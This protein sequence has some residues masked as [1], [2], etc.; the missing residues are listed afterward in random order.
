[1]RRG[2]T[3]TTL[4]APLLDWLAPPI[5][6][7]CKELYTP[8][9]EVYCEACQ[10]DPS[11]QMP[12]GTTS[13]QSC[14]EQT[15][16]GCCPLCQLAAMPL[17]TV[18]SAWNYEGAIE[19]IVKRFKYHG[20]TCLSEWIAKE[21]LSVIP[22]F[23]VYDWDYLVAVPSSMQRNRQ[24]GYEPLSIVARK[25]ARATALPLGSN[26]LQRTKKH[27]VAQAS[28]TLNERFTNVIDA[29]FVPASARR[30][31][32]N[33]RILLIDDV[34]TTGATISEAAQCLSRAGALR[35]DALCFARSTAFRKNRIA[36]F[37]SF[38]SKKETSPQ[39]SLQ[40]AVA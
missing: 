38:S 1:M 28:L 31:L 39:A 27:S 18:R 23:P 40:V 21:M 19:G 10:P 30:H 22:Q 32:E 4:L 7:V 36:S 6:V 3:L 29:F 33:T 25:I 26:L 15:A 17:A 14:G 11:L 9:T 13:C 12:Y 2:S 20:A 8:A 35:V 34:L 5:C 37:A 24:R 16:Q